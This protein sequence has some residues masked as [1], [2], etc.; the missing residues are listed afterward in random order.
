MPLPLR[1]A[2]PIHPAVAPGP[3][4]RP[5]RESQPGETRIHDTGTGPLDNAP[6]ASRPLARA[7]RSAGEWGLVGQ[8]GAILWTGSA[9]PLPPWTGSAAPLLEWTETAAPLSLWT[10]S[11][12]TL[13]MDTGAAL[14]VQMSRGPSVPVLG[15]RGASP[16]VHAGNATVP[17]QYHCTDDGSGPP[18][19][20]PESASP[21]SANNVESRGVRNEPTGTSGHVAT[22][23]R[24]A[25]SP[26]HVRTLDCRPSHH[27]VS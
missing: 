17:V 19:T 26:H 13:R 11:A 1:P 9:T 27:G 3:V 18:P 25:R 20:Q 10:H 4:P 15:Y 22:S 5:P 12:A 23:P 24:A 14:L 16:T 2:P 6:P 7:V 8:Q 21:E